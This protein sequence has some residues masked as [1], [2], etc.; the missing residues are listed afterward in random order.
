[1]IHKCLFERHFSVVIGH[2]KRDFIACSEAGRFDESSV[3][4]FWDIGRKGAL[5]RRRDD[6]LR[7]MI[8]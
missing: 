4:I 8:T 3:L 5:S 7:R 6:A 1:M 2:I